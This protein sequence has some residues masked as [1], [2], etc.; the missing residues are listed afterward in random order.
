MTCTIRGRRGFVG[1]MKTKND[2]ELEEEPLAELLDDAAADSRS[3]AN[4][5]TFN[6]PA[7]WFDLYGPGG[8]PPD[9][10]A[11][12]ILNVWPFYPYR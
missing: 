12:G 5:I 8:A 3:R 7:A 6:L 2:Q 11:A 9:F 10:D 4:D 1:P